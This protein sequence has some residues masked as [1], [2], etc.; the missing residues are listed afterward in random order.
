L[1]KNVDKGFG[2]KEIARN[3]HFGRVSKCF[4]MREMNEDE[5]CGRTWRRVGRER[6][7]RG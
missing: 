6:V 2:E 5:Y 1:T 4:G 3:I 7:E